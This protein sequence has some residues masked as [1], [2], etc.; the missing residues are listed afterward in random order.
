MGLGPAVELRQPGRPILRLADEGGLQPGDAIVQLDDTRIE[1][2][3]HLAEYIDSKE[4]GDR[5]DVKVLR[6]G[7]EVTREVTLVP[8]DV[9]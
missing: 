5:V 1:T 8:W 7:E 4:V 6:D 3:D 2:F 9:G